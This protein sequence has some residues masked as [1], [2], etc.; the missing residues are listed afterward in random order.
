M[1]QPDIFMPEHSSNSAVMNY[2]A[3]RSSHM[4]FWALGFSSLSCVVVNTAWFIKGYKTACMTTAG[5]S[6]EGGHESISAA[7][8]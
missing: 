2:T 5:S 8:Y 6:G 1:F 7:S 3:E 4:Y